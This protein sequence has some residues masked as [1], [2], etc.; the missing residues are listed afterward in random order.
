MP[1]II[2]IRYA[3]T[4]TLSLRQLDELNGVEKGTSFRAF[5]ACRNALVEGIDYF[6]LSAQDHESFINELKA[7]GHVYGTTVHLLLF[8]RSGYERVRR[9]AASRSLQ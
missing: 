1:T 6:H 2:P 8:T 3:E 9:S 7:A 5:K 4:D